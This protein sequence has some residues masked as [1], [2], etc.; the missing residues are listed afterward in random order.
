[1]KRVCKYLV[2]TLN[3]DDQIY[4]V[5][6]YGLFVVV[7]NLLNV[8]SVMF[9]GACLGEFNN[10][11]IF[12]LFFTP[13]RLYLGGYHASTALRCYILFNAISIVFILL[14]KVEINTVILQS[15]TF[16]LLFKVLMRLIA[17]K[18]NKNTITVVLIYM[19][20]VI[21]LNSYINMNV[22]TLSVLMNLMLYE[23]KYMIEK[24]R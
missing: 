22:F 1:M 6:Y 10:T 3:L 20:L 11:I 12:L 21:I 19:I 5:I 4:E 8:I 23:L 2:D 24:Y 15:I 7:T 16:F 17:L 18:Q 13:L 14:F 9:I